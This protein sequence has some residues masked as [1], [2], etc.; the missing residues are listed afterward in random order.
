MTPPDLDRWLQL[1]DATI[2]ET[3]SARAPTAVLY[4]NGTRRWVMAQGCAPEAYPAEASKAHMR[5]T[6]A[7]FRHGVRTMNPLTLH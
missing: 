5:T 2:A 7:F 1:S 6:E 4:A 3:V